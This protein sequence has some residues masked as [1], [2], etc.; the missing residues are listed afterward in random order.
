MADLLYSNPLAF[1]YNLQ[2][3]KLTTLLLSDTHG[4]HRHSVFQARKQYDLLIHAGDFTNLGREQEIDDFLQWLDQQTLFKDIIYIAGNHDI[5]YT[6]EPYV[7]LS[8]GTH[9]HYLNESSVCINGINFYGSPYTPQFYNWAFMYDPPEASAIWSKVPSDTNV[10]ISHG[11]PQGIMDEC[12]DHR[13][14]PSHAGCPALLESVLKTPS[15]KLHVFGH[16]HEGHGVVNHPC[17]R[18]SI[19][20]ASIYETLRHPP[21]EITIETE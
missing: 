5:G 8:N 13:G 7:E 16:I 18:V 1:C 15:I 9:L 10:L 21:V 17:G 3:A 2:M 4:Y 14:K 12:P 11:P 20:A 19:N 6:A